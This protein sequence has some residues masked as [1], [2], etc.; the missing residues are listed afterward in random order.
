VIVGS[1]EVVARAAGTPDT[2]RRYSR[3]SARLTPGL[4]RP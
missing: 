1:A 3:L 2:E 4:S